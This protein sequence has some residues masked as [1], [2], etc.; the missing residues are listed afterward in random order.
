MMFQILDVGD[1]MTGVVH[2][3]RLLSAALV[4]ITNVT[5]VLCCFC[6]VR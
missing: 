1:F 2:P 5:P 6:C 3:A 4:N